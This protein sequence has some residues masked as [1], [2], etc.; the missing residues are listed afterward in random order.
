MDILYQYERVLF[1]Y[2]QKLMPSLS[3]SY[4][5]S[6]AR[7]MYDITSNSAPP[8]MCSLFS[9]INSIHSCN[10]RSS[11]SK[12]LCSQYSRTNI[13]KRSFSRLDVRLLNLTPN[14][15]RSQTKKTLTKIS[16]NLFYII[17]PIQDMMQIFLTCSVLNN[18]FPIAQ[19]I[20]F[21]KFKVH[22]K[23]ILLLSLV[24]GAF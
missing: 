22:L 7:L 19:E 2:L 24:L 11:T 10:T 16:N 1:L 20:L 6:V 21:T 23:P 4:I 18:Y 14:S 9:S 15:I 3:L 17:Y 5:E 13:Q 12:N 8:N